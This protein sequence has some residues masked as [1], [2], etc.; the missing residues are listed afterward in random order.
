MHAAKA[1]A[2]HPA[3]YNVPGQP[4]PDDNGLDRPVDV[5]LRLPPYTSCCRSNRPTA[6]APASPY[7]VRSRAGAIR[8]RQLRLPCHSFP[9]ALQE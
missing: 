4:R 2:S 9:A 5:K 6:L 3:S 1:A 8:L 7:T